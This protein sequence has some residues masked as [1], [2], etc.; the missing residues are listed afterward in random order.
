MA[1]VPTQSELATFPAVTFL[2][3]SE[4]D[5]VVVPASAAT[6]DGFRAWALSDDFPERGKITFVDGG[7][8][9]DM[10]PESL[11]KHSEIK[12]EV[13][14]VL[15][16]LI[17]EKNLGR[18]HIDGALITNRSAG[19]S[20]EPDILFLSKETLK[21][22]NIELVAAKGDPESSK[23]IVG[24]VDWALEIVSP[25][26]TKKDKVLLRRAYF[27]SG[28]GEYWLVDALGQE[29]QF[30]ILVPGDSEYVAVEPQDGWL[31]SPTFDKQFK[32]ERDRDE[33]G[34]WQYTL[35]MK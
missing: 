12:S 26:S 2:D 7:V 1:T 6:H 10:S 29:I 25:S 34:F 21:S 18:L 24:T 11:E 16:N 15:L 4:M 22:G 23:E 28:M 3:D 30:D 27:K 13:S 17:R 9:V 8:I 19:V 32:L 20:N 5:P 14:R 33:D 31:A 35:H